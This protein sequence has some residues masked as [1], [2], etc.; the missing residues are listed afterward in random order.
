MNIRQRRNMFRFI[1]TSALTAL[2]VA[3]G[4]PGAERRIFVFTPV[5]YTVVPRDH[6]TSQLCPSAEFIDEDGEKYA[7]DQV[8]I[9]VQEDAEP[10]LQDLI[11]SYGFSVLTRY[12]QDL[13]DTVLLYVGVPAGA[14]PAAR[15]FFASQEGVIYA[16]LNG[17]ARFLEQS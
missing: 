9:L 6:C 2:L 12:E 13:R 17:V 10:H 1:C 3:C 16:E 7:A 15:I 14:A 5:P 11:D 4:N 8:G